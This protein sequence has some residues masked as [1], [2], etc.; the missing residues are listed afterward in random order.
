ME[1]EVY[2]IEIPIIV[3]DESEKPIEEASRRISRF[4]KSAEKTN[5]MIRQYFQ[6]IAKMKIEPYMKI[7]DNLTSS[8]IK[9]DRLLKKLDLEKASPIITAQDRVSA[10]IARINAMIDA[11]SKGK[12]DVIAEMKGPLA[13][14]V[15]KAKAALS[16][17]NNIKTGPIAELRGELFSQLTKAMSELKNVDKLIVEPK[18]TL[19]DE[20]SLK[21]R[22]IRKQLPLLT[23]KAWTV[24]LKAKDE[25]TGV[26]KKVT[27][28]LRS[29]LAMVGLGVGVGSAVYDSFKKA[30]DFEAQMSSVK[31]LTGIS[32]QELTKMQMLAIKMGAKTKYSALEAAQGI[33]EL[34]KAGLSVKQVM[35]GGLEAALNLA[36]AGDLELADAAEIMSTAMNAFRGDAISAAQAANILAGTANASATS[37]Q[38][39]R[40]SLAMV[41]AVASNIGMSFR[42]V[43][44][45]LGIFANNGLK[46]SDA[47][48]SLKTMLMNL[49]PQTKQQVEMF[50]R[51]GL[52]TKNGTSAFFDAH[53]RLKS[54]EE[55]AGLLRSRLKGLTEAQRMAALEIMF[56]SDAI[57]AANILY[58]E[59]AEGVRK[60]INE[61]SKV[62][63]LD[64]AKEKMNNAAGAIEQFRGAIETLQISALMPTM[65]LIRKFALWAADMAE[66]YTP[67]VTKE[68]EKMTKGIE[69]YWNSL[70]RNERFRKLDF[71]GKINFVIEDLS[72]KFGKWFDKKA[73]P[74]VTKYG[75]LLGRGMIDGL[76]K[77]TTAAITS[78]PLLNFLLAGYIASKVP[79]PLSVKVTVA[80]GVVFL[81]QAGKVINWLM[82]NS[83]INPENKRIIEENKKVQE[84]AK[85]WKKE[86][87]KGKVPLPNTA[88]TKPKKSITQRILEPFR[89]IQRW[90]RGYSTGGILTRPHIG[91]VAENG[92]EAIIPLSADKRN[93]ALALWTE[94]GRILGVQHYTED[95]L[96]GR[97]PVLSAPNSVVIN[98]PVYLNFDLQGLIGSVVFEN[99][100]EIEKNIDAL[101]DKIGEALKDVF[102][103]IPKKK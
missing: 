103:N 13:D 58:R 92:P 24:T 47:G 90:I 57:R 83:P 70:K 67:R 55:I 32:N 98:A 97:I 61:M 88:I 37:V 45:A 46:G 85:Q 7:R 1:S 26:F 29:P 34:L 28:A 39:L 86:A 87:E 64:V 94:T 81:G 40:Y 4:E 101:C 76:L 16:E 71:Q 72:A 12:I 89:N 62:T 74:L 19:K 54:L 35:S 63:A 14:E 75:D 44:A 10:V 82:E 66:R 100:N 42:D 8:V 96:L 77:G 25:V 6:Q 95:S 18:A 9:A 78:S 33:E 93:R 80:I 52:I 27:N 102:N 69:D 73:A 5:K 51:L 17:L 41:S 53:G 15:V 56:G 99:K 50:K 43:N 48:T 60:F 91:M 65:P 21:L 59:G 3:D 38:E 36:A 11:M 2:R 23:Q 31:A 20:I 79:G 30:I 22:E 84:T 49:I 68:I